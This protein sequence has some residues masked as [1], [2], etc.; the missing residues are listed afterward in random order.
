VPQKIVDQYNKAFPD[1]E[2]KPDVCNGLGTPDGE[3]TF[4][5]EMLARFIPQK[6]INMIMGEASI[7][8]V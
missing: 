2:H 5:S 8:N 3:Y 1:V 4:P 7:N 6:R